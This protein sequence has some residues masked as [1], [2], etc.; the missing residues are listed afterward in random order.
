VFKWHGLGQVLQPGA[1]IEDWQREA[2]MAWQLLRTRVRYAARA[3]KAGAVTE[4]GAMDDRAVLVRSDT[5]EGLSIVSPTFQV[6][7]PKQVLEFF[8][9]LVKNAGFT[10]ETAG[11]LFGGR[12]FFASA[13]V[14]A[15]AAVLDKADKVGGYLL[16]STSCDY[17]ME[18]EMRYT[19]TCVVCYNT[20]QMARAAAAAIKLSHRNEFNPQ[21]IKEKL[22][23]LPEMWAKFLTEARTL[24]KRR[25]NAHEFDR[26]LLTTLSAPPEKTEPEKQDTTREMQAYK[27]ILTLFNGGAKGADL[28]GR[29]GT[30]W[31]ALNAVTEFVDHH[32]KASS[33]EHRFANAQWGDGESLKE[34]ARNAALALL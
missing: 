21:A 20:L 31:G 15:D 17:S 12:R 23:I 1:S 2:G 26:F 4:W 10:L 8:R 18:T 16:L 28:P 27:K 32:R 24:A 29:A 6:V 3:D 9:D 13:R 19:S 33:P 22:G 30:A 14:Q 34:E 7:Q 25:V 5:R 11:T